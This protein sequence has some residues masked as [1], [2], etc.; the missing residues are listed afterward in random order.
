M[1][2]REFMSLPEAE[3]Q[4]LW[5]RLW[6]APTVRSPADVEAT[7]LAM[8]A[9]LHDYAFGNGSGDFARLTAAAEIAGS[10]SYSWQKR[11]ELLR[12]A[13]VLYHLAHGTNV[14]HTEQGHG[15]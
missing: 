13:R 9:T 4:A 10:N 12:R 15:V 2:M 1:T 6:N 11:G 7:V 8:A 14:I 5:H 3:R